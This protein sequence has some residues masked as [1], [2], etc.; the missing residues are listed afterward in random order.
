MSFTDYNK[1]N[2]Y[3]VSFELNNESIVRPEYGNA[4]RRIMISEIPAVTVD[5]DS[6]ELDIADHFTALRIA[7]IPFI[8]DNTI[9]YDNLMLRL[10]YENTSNSIETIY[11]KDFQVVPR[12]D[13][14]SLPKQ[15]TMD[16]IL[17]PKYGNSIIT[18]KKP[19][20]KMN[21]SCKFT[22]NVP[23]E[24]GGS[25][26]QVFTLKYRWKADQE[27]IEKAVAELKKSN[28][29]KDEF[30]EQSFR[31][32]DAQQEQYV[33]RMDNGEPSCYLFRI[34]CEK[35]IT[36][37]NVVVKT[38][39]IIQQK[40]MGLKSAFMKNDHDKIE[41]KIPNNSDFFCWDI[42]IMKE[43]DTLGNLLTAYILKLFDDQYG[44]GDDGENSG[45]IG[46]K[47]PHPRDDRLRIRIVSKDDNLEIKDTH[48][49][50][51]DKS[52]K[53]NLR[54]IINTI[55]HLIEL[56][57]EMRT[58]FIKITNTK[59]S[60]IEKTTN[61]ETK[62]EPEPE[63]EEKEEIVSEVEETDSEYET[64]SE[65]ENEDENDDENENENEQKEAEAEVEA[66]VK[67][68]AEESEAEESES[69]YETESDD[70]DDKN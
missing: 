70:D 51:K 52:W 35:S 62:S 17:P 61:I 10:N 44:D 7:V 63:L 57:K 32:H 47:R 31:I 20:E 1:L 53:R 59:K 22:T 21:C 25:F 67:A 58:K 18:K 2:D 26:S 69:E 13:M 19:M 38:F 23:R 45:F 4:M 27:L 15:Y 36:A 9:P 16:D 34:N 3:H 54:V 60:N 68:D 24:G 55:D 39:D 66:E 42:Y 30:D 6:V 49:I 5:L 64:D 43:D 40:L 48:D 37:N 41:V 28:K 11:L 56:T 33:K 50:D 8:Y 65:D 12:D 14:V 46:Y 29:I